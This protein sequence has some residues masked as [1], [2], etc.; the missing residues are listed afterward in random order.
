MPLLQQKYRY[1]SYLKY[2]DE[3]EAVISEKEYDT[4][5]ANMLRLSFPIMI[6]YYGHEYKDILFNVL[7]K[8]N[9]EK[10]LENE[11]MY[12]IVKKNTPSNLKRKEQIR[13]VTE[14]ELKGATGVHLS[15]PILNVKDGKIILNGKS[16]VISIQTSDD[17]LDMLATFVHELSHAFKSD[18]NSINLLQDKDENQIL[19]ERSGI[20]VTYSKVYTEGDTI[21]IEDLKEKNIGLEEGINTYDENNILNK[22]LSLPASQIPEECQELRSSLKLPDSKSKYSSEGYVQETLCAEKLLTKCGL[23]QTIRQD[24]LLGTKNSERKYNSITLNPN[25]TWEILNSKIDKS[26]RHTYERYK[27]MFDLQWFGEHKDEIIGNLQDIHSMLDE[28]A[29]SKNIDSL[30][31]S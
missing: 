28:C 19:I 2:H 9:I 22:I 20:S 1:N 25:N 24:Q 16:D 11:T 12:D 13:A 30:E 14:D 31:K 4:D 7:R 3:L 15:T 8:I 26:V 27:N 10:P 5:I 18:Q 6:E 17:K 21:V 29:Q 23:K